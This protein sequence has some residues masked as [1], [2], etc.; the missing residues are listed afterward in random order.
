MLSAGAEP[1]T[2][3]V[4]SVHVDDGKVNGIGMGTGVV[5]GVVKVKDIAGMLEGRPFEVG[6][7]P[8]LNPVKW[9]G[10]VLK[11]ETSCAV[12]AGVEAIGAPVACGG[13]T[14]ECT[15][16]HGG[17]GRG[18]EEVSVRKV[19]VDELASQHGPLRRMG[20]AGC[21][22]GGRNVCGLGG[23]WGFGVRILKPV[24]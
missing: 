12:F 3:V 18:V 13:L 17:R 1:S 20:R 14:A 19:L 15:A 24:S 9:L 10:L 11:N 23:N 7:G 8:A 16:C 4:D 6:R 21:I 22:D 5:R 2:E